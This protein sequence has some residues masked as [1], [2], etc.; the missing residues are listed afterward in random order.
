MSSETSQNP[1]LSS[2][3]L[4]LES[5]SEQFSPDSD[6]AMMIAHISGQGNLI[7]VMTKRVSV[8]AST[9]FN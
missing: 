7:D 1:A 3:P 5:A 8:S 2:E 4:P 6:K 9:S